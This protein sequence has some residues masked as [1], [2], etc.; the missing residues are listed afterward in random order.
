MI[1]LFTKIGGV[2]TDATLWIWQIMKLNWLWIVHILLGGVILG[3]FPAT[4]AMFS[5][6]RKWLRDGIDEPFLKEY[7][8]KFKET[9]LESN[10]LGFVYLMVGLFL[11]YDLYLVT[12]I[13]GMLSLI[14]SLIIIFL[15]VMYLISLF[16]FFSY[17]VH[18]K[19]TKKN[20]LLKPIIIAFISIKQNIVIA[21]G[22][23]MIGY[24]TY[25][26]PGL[27]LFSIGVL[28]SFW[29][30]KVSLNRYKD[31]ENVTNQSVNGG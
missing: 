12:Q 23:L 16:Y 13:Q 4:M 7:H 25:Q 14:S 29:V 27:L 9:F 17:Y 6:T 28:V 19:D 21:I 11:L 15:I 2:F 5:I 20:Y 18:F 3:F 10:V 1:K 30:M 26:L 22:L 8:N 31:L 24:L